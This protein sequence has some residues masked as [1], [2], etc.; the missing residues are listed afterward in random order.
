MIQLSQN[1]IEK[2]RYRFYDTKTWIKLKLIC[3]LRH[4]KRTYH[5]INK[6]NKWN[7]QLQ[8]SWQ[9]PTPWLLEPKLVQQMNA[10][11]TLIDYKVNRHILLIPALLPATW[12]P[13]NSRIHLLK[14]THL[15]SSTVFKKEVKMEVKSKTIRM[16]LLVQVLSGLDQLIS[17][18]TSVFGVKKA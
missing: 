6:T 15:L 5:K 10:P 12:L 2:S 13:V 11:Q 1:I 3:F 16:L 8:V 9:H 4:M 17:T 18:K 14:L 7:S